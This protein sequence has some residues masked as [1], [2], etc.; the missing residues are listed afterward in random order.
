MEFGI[1]PVHLKLTALFLVNSVGF[2]N[3]NFD[4]HGI[5]MHKRIAKTA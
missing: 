2:F 1:R 4:I 5:S 3:L